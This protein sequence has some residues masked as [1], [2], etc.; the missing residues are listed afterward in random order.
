MS[1]SSPGPDIYS[2]EDDESS[3]DTPPPPPPSEINVA[4][5]FSRNNG[6]NNSNNVRN[7]AK[8]DDEKYHEQLRMF[9]GMAD[10]SNAPSL[11]E[12]DEDDYQDS[13]DDDDDD[14]EESD[15]SPPPKNYGDP[16]FW[17]RRKQKARDMKKPMLYGS[18]AVGLMIL[19]IIILVIGITTGSFQGGEPNSRGGGA[20]GSSSNPS[21][22]NPEEDERATRLRQY[23]MSVG[24][25]GNAM[26]NDPISPE[27]QALAWMQYD[28]P[29]ALD[30]IDT[31]NHLRIDQRF[32]LLTLWFQSDFEWFNQNNWL[33][34]DECTW[35]GVTC[36]LVTPG[37]RRRCLKEATGRDRKLQ[38]G[39]KL[40]ALVDLENNNLQGKIP[41]DLGLLRWLKTL[42]LSRNNIAGSIPSTL[43]KLEYLE[44]IYLDNNK[45]TGE[46][47][48]DF[49]T[50]P[51]LVTIDISN[52]QIGGPIPASM[53][54]ATELQRI[55]LSNNQFL[56]I[57][58]EEVGNLSNLGKC[59]AVVKWFS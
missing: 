44:E 38:D 35:H 12:S 16:S 48:L 55:Y 42:N 6:N 37:F 22:Y 54:T 28:D 49:S 34:D 11:R 18:I 57:I 59:V 3:I 26:F 40:V 45:L 36:I 51:E 2:D 8:S 58:A 13:T 25:Q 4:S 30:P 7:N 33:T 53:W 27:S 39:D 29:V 21:S 10:F 15:V 47:T 56:G 46:L 32:A 20:G 41:P 31:D 19:I 24:D 43:S 52:N 5:P 14:D 23:L 9:K 1:M 50:M 17:Q